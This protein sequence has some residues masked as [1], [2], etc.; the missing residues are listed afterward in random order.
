[1]DWILVI[2]DWP[3]WLTVVNMLIKFM[4]YKPESHKIVAEEC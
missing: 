3:Y 1:V 4:F 2:Q